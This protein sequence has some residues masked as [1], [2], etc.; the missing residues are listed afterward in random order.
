[1]D[2]DK[3]DGVIDGLVP[4]FRRIVRGQYVIALSGSIAKGKAD[5]F[6]DVDFWIFAEGA[7]D[8]DERR[9]IMEDYSDTPDDVYIGGKWDQPAE[10]GNLVYQGV[11]VESSLQSVGSGERIIAACMAGKIAVEPT[12][13][14]I[15]G[16]YN[17]CTLS[18]IHS[19]R[20][21][22][23]PQAILR[24]W[25]ERLAVYPPKL[26]QAIVDKHL[27][28]AHFWI[29][30]FHYLSAIERGDVVYTAG[31]VQQTLHNL[32][33]VLFAVNEAYF[34]GDKKALDYVDGFAKKPSDFRE[35]V[36][37]LLTP[38]NDGVWKNQHGILKGL[39][40]ALEGLIG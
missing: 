31:I 36:H 39:V 17:H 32:I 6:S 11:T 21:L 29:D 40:M 34:A 5:A 27:K 2:R 1:M 24:E 37:H 3:L 22:D 25:K 16:Y 38:M 33:Q 19:A 18:V 28:D 13:W 26:K 30:N 8:W 9:A 12:V 10:Y 15:H 4:M 7:V 35:H 20:G 14:T 23:D